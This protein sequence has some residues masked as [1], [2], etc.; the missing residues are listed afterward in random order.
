MRAVVIGIAARAEQEIRAYPRLHSA[1]YTVVTRN[2][3][4]RDL[5]GRVKDQVRGA[6]PERFLTARAAEEPEVQARR[7]EAVARRLGLDGTTS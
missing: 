6:R 4:A 5:L 2:A 3:A 1:F 7:R